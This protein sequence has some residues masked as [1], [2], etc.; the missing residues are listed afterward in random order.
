[1]TDTQLDF[2][3]SLDTGSSVTEEML[4]RLTRQV[5]K[6]LVSL[7]AT[8]RRA[9][10]G[11]APADTKGFSA[12]INTLIVTLAS[13]G[14]LTA[15]IQLL[16][17]WVLRA[18]GRKVRI[19]TEID[20]NSIELEYPPTAISEEELMALTDKLMQMLNKPKVKRPTRK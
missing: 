12:E 2:I 6:D 20:G 9:Q 5:H 3:I 7:G 14:V 10:G 13:A 11:E 18:E 1:M 17:D 4:D 16:K 15:I 19:K 8:V